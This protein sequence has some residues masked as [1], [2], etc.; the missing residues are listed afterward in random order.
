MRL[1]SGKMMRL[2][3]VVNVGVEYGPVTIERKDQARIVNV[4]GGVDNRSLGEV[5]SDIEK[6]I[7]E[8]PK[9]TDN[10][11]RELGFK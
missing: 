6:E 10:I 9:I 3:N 11:N 4:T 5:V 7:E 8:Q 2:D 1:P